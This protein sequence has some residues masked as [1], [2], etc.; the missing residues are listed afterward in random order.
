[1]RYTK[2]PWWVDKN[3]IDPKIMAEW[4]KRNL[5]NNH[6]LPPP[7]IR[8][9]CPFELPPDDFYITT[10]KLSTEEELLNRVVTEALPKRTSA[11]KSRKPRAIK[12]I[13]NP[14]KSDLEKDEIYQ[15]FLFT[16]DGL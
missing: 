14:R 8:R 16:T 11:H 13:K 6:I 15:Q 3:E 5:F 1:M 7:E 10:T 12:I 4:L 9:E 2:K